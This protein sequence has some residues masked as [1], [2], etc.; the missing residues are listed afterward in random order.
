MK[1]GP[2]EGPPGGDLE[3]GLRQEIERASGGRSAKRRLV[4]RDQPRN[5]CVGDPDRKGTAG[6]ERSERDGLDTGTQEP[7]PVTENAVDGAFAGG[8]RRAAERVRRGVVH[9]DDGRTVG[10]VAVEA[11]GDGGPGPE[12]RHQHQHGR[13]KRAQVGPDPVHGRQRSKAASGRAS[14]PSSSARNLSYDRE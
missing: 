11:M 2:R 4:G 1:R 7:R 13:G 9:H 8:Q 6:N 10:I 3:N 12:H 5:C 14:R